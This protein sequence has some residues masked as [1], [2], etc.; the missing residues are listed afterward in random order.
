MKHFYLVPA[1]AVVAATSRA[2][3]ASAWA[4]QPVNG[5]DISNASVPA[6]EIR[7]G[8]PPR[9]G[10]PSIDDPKFADV[11]DIDFLKPEDLVFGIEVDGERRAYP[12]RVL[13]WHEIVNDVIGEQAVAITYCPLCG[14]AMAFDRK[15]GEQTL[16]FGV[17]GLLYQSD[18]LMYDRETESLWSQLAMKSISGTKIGTKLNWLSGELMSWK[19]WSDR[20]PKSKL[21]TTETGHMRSYDHDAYRGYRQTPK[22][23]FPV[24]QNRT[25]LEN[26]A[27][28]AGVVV[29][30]KAAAFSLDALAD[31]PEQRAIIELSDTP[32]VIRYHAESRRLT[33]TD[34]KGT[35]VPVVQVYWFAW[36]A[37]YP[38]TVLWRGDEH[39]AEK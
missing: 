33:A 18:V 32:L 26:K 21:L 25:E 27:W 38:D 15:F 34:E 11:A 30:G 10:I 22:L 23:M 24:P 1:L 7:R 20:Y 31:A 5:F 19:A 9:D 8:G 17:S 3:I 6:N 35:P 28:V 2:T 12:L 37:F 39:V 36:Q 13:V 16:N 29:D 4:E 14:T